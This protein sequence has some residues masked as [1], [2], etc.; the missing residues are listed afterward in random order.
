MIFNIFKK[1][2]LIRQ[3]YFKRNNTKFYSQF[4]EDKMLDEIIP[5]TLKN[6]FYV[7]VGSFHPIKHS[8]THLLF[9]RGWFGI[10]IDMEIDK[11]NTFKLAR[12][13]DFN[14][15]GAV[16]DKVEKVKIIRNQKFGVSSTIN[17]DMIK[18][19]DIIDE[20]Y[21]ETVTLDNILNNSP[22]KN[23]EIDLVNIDT[24]GNDFKVLKSLNLETYN[25]KIIII[26]THLKNIDEI[27]KSDMYIYLTAKKYN[28]K[29]WNIY[30][31]IFIKENYYEDN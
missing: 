9:C 16:S 19:E 21:I 25:P 4:G 22:F 24:E 14:Y 18:K 2:S 10:N 7:D 29:S 11:I 17:S 23:K 30:S 27:I 3:K 31:L 15:L 20:S 26:E 8:N 1:I 28:L 5:R 12:P 13:N 6:G